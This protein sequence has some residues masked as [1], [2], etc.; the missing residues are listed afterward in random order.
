VEEAAVTAVKSVML[1]GLPGEQTLDYETVWHCDQPP[2]DK[3]YVVTDQYW[4]GNYSDRHIK[5][6]RITGDREGPS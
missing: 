2:G 6:I 4:N 1:A 5:E 3:T